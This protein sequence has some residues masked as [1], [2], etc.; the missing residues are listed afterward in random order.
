[1]Y[2]GKRMMEDILDELKD[3]KRCATLKNAG[4]QD[5]IKEQNPHPN[6]IMHE[7]EVTDFIRDRVKT[8]HTAWIVNPLDD[9][10][11]KIE[12]ELGG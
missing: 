9:I 2:F 5:C 4:F 11:K 8:H 10:I 3:I 1:M 7:S 12:D 6:I